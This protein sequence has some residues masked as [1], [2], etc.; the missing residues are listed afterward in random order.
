MPLES[1]CNTSFANAII[2]AIQPTA[3]S[4]KP[5]WMSQKEKGEP[6][7]LTD[8]N[9]NRLMFS[10]KS[11]VHLIND[12]IKHC[13]ENTGG[14]I[15]STFMKSINMYDLAN[16]ISDEIEIVGLRP[17]ERLNEKLISEKELPFTSIEDDLI[18]LKRELNDNENKLEEEYSSETADKMSLQEI[19]ELINE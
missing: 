9:M 4:V 13:E 1:D 7:K 6:L 16:I 8:K 19:L 3:I 12:S 18:L 11:A 15:S 10:Q 17:G 14:F 5:F 2:P